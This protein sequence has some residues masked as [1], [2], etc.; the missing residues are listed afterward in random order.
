M[1]NSKV[2]VA[3]LVAL[4]V[5]GIRAGLVVGLQADSNKDPVP[6]GAA[7]AHKEGREIGDCHF[8]PPPDANPSPRIG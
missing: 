7:L 3:V 2:E 6:D 1:A 4:A 8:I 5:A